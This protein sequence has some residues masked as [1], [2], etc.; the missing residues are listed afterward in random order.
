MQKNQAQKNS[1]QK[2]TTTSRKQWDSTMD[3][4]AIIHRKQQE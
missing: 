2:P 1:E 4:K 3:N